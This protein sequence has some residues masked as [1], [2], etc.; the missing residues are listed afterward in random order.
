[1]CIS[2][3]KMVFYEKNDQVCLQ[4]RKLHEYFPPQTLACSR[5]L[6]LTS[7][8][9]R[10]YSKAMQEFPCGPAGEGCSFVTAVAWVPFLARELLVP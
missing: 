3:V 8:S 7:H 1:M 4:L 10:E 9:V 5:G 2:Q 6:M